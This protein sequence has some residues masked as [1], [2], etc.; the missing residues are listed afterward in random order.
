M[1]GLSLR[2]TGGP[3]ICPP[4]SET[5]KI[6]LSFQHP[7]PG[8]QSLREIG[9]AWETAAELNDGARFF[10]LAIPFIYAEPFYEKNLDFLM[11]R[12]KMFKSLL[13]REWFEGFIRLSRSVKD[14]FI[15]GKS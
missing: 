3:A 13:T 6:I 14:Y 7:Q 8:Q 1:M 11:E 2:G 10:Q 5:N 4:T 9:K 12:Q 15:S